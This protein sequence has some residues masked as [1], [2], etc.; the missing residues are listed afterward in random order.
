MKFELKA[1]KR[2]VQGSGAS[3]R[4]R[5]ANLVPAIVY[6]GNAAPQQI[7]L[8]HNEIL[9]SLRKEASKSPV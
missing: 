8:D 2:T 3:R 7:E 4:L 9:L 6:G 1:Q 5:R